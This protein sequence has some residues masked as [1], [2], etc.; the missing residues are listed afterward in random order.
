MAYRQRHPGGGWPAIF[1][2]LGKALEVGPWRLW[3]RMRSRNACKTCAVGMGGQSG[4]MVNEA[5]HFPEV[6]KK[7]LQAQ[8]AD[9]KGAIDVDFFDRN[10][11]DALRRLTPKQAEDAGRLTFPVV[12]DHASRKFK[13]ISWDS[14]YATIGDALKKTTPERAAFYASGRSSNE[15][16]F[17][18]QSF[19][20]VYGS[21][22]VMN[23]TYYCHQASGVGLKM[24][25]GT[26]TATINLDDV[27]RCDLVVLLGA[28]PASNHPR[29]MTVLHD[30]RKRGGHVIVVNPVRE[31]GLEKFHVP[32]KVG[33]LLF[34]TEISSFYVQPLNGGDVGL[35]VG[36]LKSLAEKNQVDNDFLR[37]YTTGWEAAI[38]D[39]Q[40]TSWQKIELNSGVTRADIEKMAAMIGDAK[41]VVF[42]WAM[43]L[44]HHAWGV[45][46]ILAL[47]NVALATG[48]IGRPGAGLLPIRGHSNVQGVG[49]VG[50]APALQDA[51]RTSLE[52]LYKKEMPT[53]GGLD[54]W[55]M[56]DAAGKGNIDF[57]F[58]LGGNLWGSNP[59]L[60]WATACMENIKTTVYLSTKLN[61]GH[62][63]ALGQTTLILP[64]L[65]R[66]EEP[67]PTTQESMFNFVRLSDGGT[68]NMPGQMK[69]ES[70]VICEIANRV[71]GNSPVDW[72]ILRSHKQV[73][74]L[75]AEAIPGW[76]EISTIDETKRE[77]TITGRVFHQ[78][79]FPTPDGKAAMHRTP[80]TEFKHDGLRLITLRSE[81][82][83]NTV[84]Y[85]EHDFYRGIPHRFCLLISSED[86]RRLQ[87]SDGERITVRGEAG[88]LDNIELVVGKIRPGVVAMF[89][90]EANVLIKANIDP[91]SKTPAFK[92]APVWL[93]KVGAKQRPVQEAGVR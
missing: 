6:C 60:T 78:P 83:F 65:A 64:V 70:E 46:N 87:M 43:G 49:S 86:A 8:A 18:L 45:D 35:L 59:D 12:Y 50:F 84:V 80:L 23:C 9:M 91:R 29:L 24:A 73:R 54:T 10:D 74:K 55:G 3:K 28:N 41:S 57:L 53:S 30:L 31:S 39:A 92:S 1:Y 72:N 5:G 85:E 7:S 81:G 16:A 34:G 69:A 19:A 89:Y 52:R 48:N 22:H 93:E 51:V 15:A 20:R 47:S 25:F 75:I 40:N 58:A 88:S 26:G 13:P 62:F 21:N 67:Q 44:T 37:N 63:Q 38:A 77:F 61:P 71:L 2:T 42:A 33:S 32:S 36:V 79:K 68:V 76:Q 56:M 90:P 66:D 4:G 14:A 82:Q 17:L 11:I 27:D